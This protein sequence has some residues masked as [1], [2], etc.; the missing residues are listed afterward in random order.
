MN[1]SKRA[2]KE[3]KKSILNCL[4]RPKQLGPAVGDKGY[5]YA[6][7]ACANARSPR[8]TGSFS[9][10]NDYVDRKQRA[11]ISFGR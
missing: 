6:S 3:F 7:D 11:S 2:G 1:T 9:R 5:G 10:E 4:H 8:R